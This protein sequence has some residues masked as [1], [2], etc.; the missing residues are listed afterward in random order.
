MAT[1]NLDFKIA[2]SLFARQALML[3]TDGKRLDTLISDNGHIWGLSEMRYEEAFP[4]LERSGMGIFSKKR[5]AGK[6]RELSLACGCGAII[7][8]AYGS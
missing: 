7:I 5:E 2:M 8:G 1:L 6:N 3:M 4:L